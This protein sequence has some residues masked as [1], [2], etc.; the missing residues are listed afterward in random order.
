MTVMDFLFIKMKKLFY[1]MN[2]VKIIRIY[3][4]SSETL[5]WCDEFSLF[6]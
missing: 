6:Y 1:L 3:V 2:L 5:F 4:I